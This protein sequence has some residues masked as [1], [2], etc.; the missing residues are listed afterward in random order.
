MVNMIEFESLP[1]FGKI[2]SISRIV[3]VENDDDRYYL[4]K[5]YNSLGNEKKEDFVIPINLKNI[6]GII[7]DYCND[8]RDYLTKNENKYI[9]LKN[10]KQVFNFSIST[11]KLN[12]LDKI[13]KIG[14]CLGTALVG[15]TFSVVLFPIVFY[16]GMIVLVLSGIGMVVVSDINKEVEIKQFV[17]DYDDYSKRLGDYKSCLDNKLSR[18]LTEYCG[19][20]NEKNECIENTL[21]ISR[22][23]KK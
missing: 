16:V 6:K 22:V 12:L 18:N 15:L 9:E 20:N 1:Y 11:E 19:L 4:V 14:L 8:V 13:T 23:K 2:N 3:K 7:E 21:R 5:R 17:N 10:K